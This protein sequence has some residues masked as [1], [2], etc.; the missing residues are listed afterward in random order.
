MFHLLVFF[1]AEV[2]INSLAINPLSDV[3]L[4]KIFSQYV[5]Y[6]FTQS[7]VYFD[8]EKILNFMKPHE[9]ITGLISWALIGKVLASA[10]TLKSF[11]FFSY[12]DVR[13]LVLTVVKCLFHLE[14]CTG[15]KIRSRSYFYKWAPSFLSTLV[16][17]DCLFFNVYFCRWK[18]SEY[19]CL[20]LDSIPLICTSVFGMHSFLIHVSAP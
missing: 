4:T 19:S 6:S 7:A 17:R 1:G 5:G 10:C 8:A 18:F 3:Q 11:P 12:N 16:I 20:D 9:L 15:W 14:I 2:F 13:I